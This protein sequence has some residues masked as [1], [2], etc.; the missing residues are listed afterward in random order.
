MTE[1]ERIEKFA[2]KGQKWN[3]WKTH[4]ERVKRIIS[5]KTKVA[6]LLIKAKP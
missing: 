6:A 5:E 3:V 4:S 2:R 1:S